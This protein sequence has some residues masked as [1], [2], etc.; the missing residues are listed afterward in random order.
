MEILLVNLGV[1]QTT[2]CAID[3]AWLRDSR[4]FAEQRL[5]SFDLMY[6]GNVSAIELPL[7]C[8]AHVL[9][10]WLHKII[11]GWLS[12]LCRYVAIQSSSMQEAGRLVQ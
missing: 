6:I 10:L 3:D 12:I 8:L 1:H 5:L 9:A 4:I 2:R 7:G 11:D